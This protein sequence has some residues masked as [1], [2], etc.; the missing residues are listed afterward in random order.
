MSELALARFVDNALEYSF[1][2]YNFVNNE[3]QLLDDMVDEYKRQYEVHRDLTEARRGYEEWYGEKL[4]KK[5][6]EKD[7]DGFK[8]PFADEELQFREN[9]S[10]KNFLYSVYINPNRDSERIQIIADNS[11]KILEYLGGN[12]SEESLQPL[13]ILFGRKDFT[14][15]ELYFMATLLRAAE[16]QPL[17]SSET[18]LGNLKDNLNA[19]VKVVK[20]LAKRFTAVEKQATVV[21]QNYGASMLAASG[22]QGEMIG[23]YLHLKNPKNPGFDFNALNWDSDYILGQTVTFTGKKGNITKLSLDPSEPV[24]DKYIPTVDND[25]FITN[26]IQDDDGT[27]AKEEMPLKF[28]YGKKSFFSTDTSKLVLDTAK[29]KPDRTMSIDSGIMKTPLNP[30]TLY[31]TFALAAPELMNDFFLNR[32]MTVSGTMLTS[33]ECEEMMEAI[34]NVINDAPT[35]NEDDT[36]D[37]QNKTQVGTYVNALGAGCFA[38]AVN[39][40]EF[41]RDSEYKDHIENEVLYDHIKNEVLDEVEPIYILLLPISFI[42]KKLGIQTTMYITFKEKDTRPF[43]IG[44][45]EGKN[46]FGFTRFSI[47]RQYIGAV[48]PHFYTNDLKQFSNFEQ[49][50]I[51]NLDQ[52]G[53]QKNYHELFL[54]SIAK[55]ITFA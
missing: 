54:D 8:S 21:R 4:L 25:D 17:P 32:G 22:V 35:K 48:L 42:F 31:A 40:A 51:K 7:N 18:Q 6:T 50:Y 39:F 20:T 1:V 52:E 46:P 55:R 15:F 23:K 29:L 49:H 36:I 33:G 13:L 27:Y 28:A 10:D 41:F 38:L 44:D 47:S 26:S 9:E 19:F 2:L 30:Y 3:K 34:E 12:K 53:L 5:F 37:I 43:T 14:P 45:P 24:F 16:G 11:T